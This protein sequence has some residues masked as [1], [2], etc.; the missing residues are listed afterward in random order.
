MFDKTSQNSTN[1]N[2]QDTG[3]VVNLQD[4][5]KDKDFP[6]KKIGQDQNSA[7]K[8]FNEPAKPPLSAEDI[9]SNVDKK[10][11]GAVDTPLSVNSNSVG[12]YNNGNNDLPPEVNQLSVQ[13][14]SSKVLTII[15]IFLAVIL[16]GLAVFWVYVRY[17][18][19]KEEVSFDNLPASSGQDT[20]G[21]SLENFAKDLVQLEDKQP[22]DVS[23]EKKEEIPV[24][25]PP[26]VEPEIPS[27][28][29]TDG[30]SDEEEIFLGTNPSRA[31]TD[32]DGLSDYDEVKTYLT[33]PVKNDTD[34]DGYMDGIEVQNG[35]NPNGPGKL[36]GRETIDDWKLFVNDKYGYSF[37]YP[38]DLFVDQSNLEKITVE[39]LAG[40][41]FA[42]KIYPVEDG[43]DFKSFIEEKLVESF[44]NLLDID[45]VK[46]TQEDNNIISVEFKNIVGGYSGDVA[47]TFIIDKNY[48]YR[49]SAFQ[50]YEA[51]SQIEFQNQILSGF[52]FVD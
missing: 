13:P 29:D 48:M 23:L 45:T 14:K 18:S 1:N 4:L 42:I 24:V 47:W 28:I 35:Y 32:L 22:K 9:F 39:S 36:G 52:E 6:F 15:I 51:L 34:S 27:D 12:Q 33:N 30:L 20:A 3:P 25:E 37:K 46:W 17:L 49:I 26:Y 2:L 41:Y 19:P 16:V 10:P 21:G 38:K 44:G 50:G 40:A 8:I 11:T 31:D 7:T 5:N 43:K